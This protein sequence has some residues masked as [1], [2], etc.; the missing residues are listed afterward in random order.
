M[1]EAIREELGNVAEGKRSA[2]SAAPFYVLE[3]TLMPA[4]LVELGSL[5][6]GA[7]A[8]RLL[9]PAYQER[10]AHAIFRGIS[11]YLTGEV[12][13]AL[14]NGGVVPPRAQLAIVIDDF[15]GA[16]KNGTPAF[17]ALRKPLTF[18]VMPNFPDSASVAQR[19]V[20]LG[21][22][23]LVHLPME[24]FRGKASHLG[25]GT[26]Y[27]HLNDAEIE[28]RVHAAIASVPGAVGVNN[29]MGSRATADARVMRT[30]LRV[31]RS[32]GMFFLDSRTTD[33]SVVCE[34][35][36]E[37]GVPCGKRD[38]FLDNVNEIGY[39]KE[40]LREAARIARKRGSAVVIGHVGATGAN[41]AQA[42]R[43]MLR[44][45]EAQGVELKYLST[46]ILN[47]RGHI[48]GGY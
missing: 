6:N 34:V 10:L 26:I 40:R 7:E 23:V 16:P 27:V 3:R 35:A 8:A 24:P 4:V 43:E 37:L 5:I 2:A 12:T 45:L 21:Y 13:P 25:P 9:D 1:A 39:I 11:R 32:Y 22:Q 42:I 15:A 20:Q 14:A 46:V 30:V 17:F 44:E 33:R 36:A 48:A 29:H 18:A 28:Q 38:C 41:T 31:V 19:A 47:D